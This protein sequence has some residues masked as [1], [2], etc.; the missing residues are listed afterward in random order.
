M[1]ADEGWTKAGMDMMHK[2]DSFVHETLRL[3]PVGD[4]SLD[5]FHI[6][7][8]TN[9]SY[10]PSFSPVIMTRLV[11]RPFTFSNGVTIPSG[12]LLSIPLRAAHVD[13]SIYENPNEFDGFRF[14]KLRKSEGDIT[15]S[16]YQAVAIST[17][18]LTFGLGRH[19]W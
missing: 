5:S 18:S 16:R 11:L 3:D 6:V 2:I 9:H 13:E 4:S 14:A 7:P 19:A 15:G 1:V 8:I 12:T 17:E 10:I